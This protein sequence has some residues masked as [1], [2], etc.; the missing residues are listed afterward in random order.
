MGRKSQRDVD[1]RSGRLLVKG[2]MMVQ[3]LKC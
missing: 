3:D 2:T 1:R